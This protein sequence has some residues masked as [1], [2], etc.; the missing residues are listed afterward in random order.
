MKVVAGVVLALVL[1]AGCAN[2]PSAFDDETAEAFVRGCHEPAKGEGLPED[3]CRCAYE[4]I[5]DSMTFE[6]FEALND[7]IARL[8]E[9]K[10]RPLEP[11]EVPDEVA[12]HF[13]ACAGDPDSADNEDTTTSTLG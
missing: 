3:V 10:G 5:A 4:R 13:A 6:E 1:V 7:E 9:E 12:D 8:E 11:D 2:G